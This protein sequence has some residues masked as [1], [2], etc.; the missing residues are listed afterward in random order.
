[1]GI[2]QLKGRRL[3]STTDREKATS[4]LAVFVFLDRSSR[5]SIYVG[6]I[7]SFKYVENACFPSYLWCACVRSLD[8]VRVRLL[9]KAY[10]VL[11]KG[12]VIFYEIDRYVFEGRCPYQVFEVALENLFVAISARKLFCA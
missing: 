11:C 6:V 2:I 7:F 1:M 12:E 4:E 9:Y 10:L 3:G 8:Q 5:F